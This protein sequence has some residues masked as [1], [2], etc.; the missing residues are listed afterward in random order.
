VLATFT[1]RGHLGMLETAD[2]DG[3]GR[4]EILVGG[5]AAE[6]DEAELIVLEMPNQMAGSDAT[7]DLARPVDPPRIR[8]KAALIFPRTSV[9]RK[10][11]ESNRIAHIADSGDLLTVV[12][13]ELS[14]DP[15]VEVTYQLDRQFRVKDVWFSDALKNMHRNLNAQGILDHPLSEEDVK[16]FRNITRLLPD[17]NHKGGAGSV[18]AGQ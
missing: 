4:K 3:C 18:P 11:E 12:V 16:G 1:H 8:E 15:S 14:D 13:S 2:V 6:R 7:A 5:F 9:N 17:H 10:L